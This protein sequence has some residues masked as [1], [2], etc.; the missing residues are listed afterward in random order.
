MQR[1]GGPELTLRRG[2]TGEG[3][4]TGQ[5]DKVFFSQKRVREGSMTLPFTD[6]HARLGEQ[7]HVNSL[8]WLQ[9]EKSLF[10]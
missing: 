7:T 8:A 3:L 9:E 10:G 2:E 5:N 6:F 1:P 4:K